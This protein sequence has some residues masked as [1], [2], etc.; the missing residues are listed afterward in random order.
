MPIDEYDPENERERINGP[1]LE[2][3]PDREKPRDP[4][5]PEEWSL[6]IT[7]VANGYIANGVDGAVVF[8]EDE[9]CRRD[10]DPQ[11][12][13][14]LLDHVIEYFGAGGSRYDE[15]RVR[16]IIEPGDKYPGDDKAN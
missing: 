15:A 5:A 14:R 10:V 2:D 11:A 16:V 9:N 3:F 1:I 12:V 6:H 13:A 8:E 7:R 4:D